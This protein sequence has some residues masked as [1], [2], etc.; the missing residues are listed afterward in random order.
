MSLK[1]IDESVMD[2][3]DASAFQ[4]QKPYPWANP[5]GFL[6][7]EGF[8]RLVDSLPPPELFDERFGEKRKHGQAPHDRLALEYRPDLP[9]AEPW[10]EFVDE[11]QSPAYRRFL[12]RMFGRSALRLALH[13]HYTP[14]GCSVSPHCDARRKLGSHIFYLNTEQDWQVAWGGE[15]LILDDS[16]R[17][18]ADS[19][20]KF[21]D[22]DR[23]MPA[24]TLGNASLLF[25]RRERSWHGV[26]EIRCPPTRL[27]RVFIVVI[28]DWKLPA[29][30]KS[31]FRA[32]KNRY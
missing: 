28:E 15:T 16:G 18:R 26:K 5:D 7:G 1:Y 3:L 22:F 27:R 32:N 10:R 11:L 23:V 30:L 13:W 12:E 2:G 8:A 9:L 31:L 19:A 24:R 29:R 6:T 4:Q 25:M 21:E 20:P 17:F 14:N